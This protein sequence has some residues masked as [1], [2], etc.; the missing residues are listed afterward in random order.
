M[1][2]SSA[3]HVAARRF[4]ID[5]YHYWSGEYTRLSDVGVERGRG[6]SEVAYG[7]FP[8]YRLDEAIRVEVEKFAGTEFSSLEEARE[9][10]LGAGRRAFLSLVQ[11]FHQSRE[12]CNAL[13]DE[14]EAF[15]QYVC[16]LLPLQLARIEPLPYRRVLTETE[17]VEIRRKLRDRWGVAGYW[18][19]LSKCE[20][21]TNVIAFHQELWERRR[22]TDLLCEA[23]ESRAIDRCWL[24]L[25]G[26]YNY[27]IDRTSI[28]PIYGGDE[29]FVTS[30]FEWLL[31]CS[32]ESSI[33]VAGWL[34]DL[35]RARWQDWKE[36]AYGGPFHTVDLRG[37]W[38]WPSS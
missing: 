19:P 25:E 34:A 22:G 9:A 1:N 26:P 3:L 7:L 31:Y 28:A 30:D 17:S 20:P 16:G 35:F 4:C 33:T 5:Q 32:H 24:M 8:R 38:D 6:Y 2:F 11:E 36:V 12:A 15:E 29:W 13:T 14:S 10:I 37:T 23:L 27:E 18:F 21:D